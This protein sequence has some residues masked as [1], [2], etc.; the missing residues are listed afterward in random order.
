M[1]R[2]FVSK[3]CFVKEKRGGVDNANGVEKNEKMKN[4]VVVIEKF[5]LGL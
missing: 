5:W 3:D 4:V 1:K 2:C